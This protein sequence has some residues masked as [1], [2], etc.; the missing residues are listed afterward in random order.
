MMAMDERN[1]L[2][3]A[4]RR[5]TEPQG[6]PGDLQS[7]ETKL[8]QAHVIFGWLEAGDV[9]Q[10]AVNT[11]SVGNDPETIKSEHPGTD[12][13]GF[14]VEEQEKVLVPHHD[15]LVISLT[16]ANCLVKRILVESG[17]SCNII[18]HAA[19]QGLGLED[20]ALIRRVTPLFGLSGE[21]KR[22]TGETILP[23]YAEGVSLHTKF[24]VVNC[25][26]SYNGIL[27]RAWIHSMGAVPSTLHQIIKFPTPWGIRAIKGDQETAH[28]CYQVALKKWAEVAPP[29]QSTPQAPHMVEPEI[30]DM[31][32][33]PLIE[34]NSTRNLKIG[35]KLSEGLRRMLIEFK[36][37]LSRL[38]PPPRGWRNK[39][40]GVG[41]HPTR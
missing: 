37:V 20:N 34:G 38:R 5:K 30:E 36:A 4:V 3:E 8:H 10:P 29:S 23:T 12:K 40:L 9:S 11:N 28:H 31:D 41:R 2:S 17:S 14:T 32:D 18:F 19:Y 33:M 39:R 25:H 16:I 1:E 26:S 15:A 35:S 27:G 13:I 21:I 7:R 22:T 6:L 24:P